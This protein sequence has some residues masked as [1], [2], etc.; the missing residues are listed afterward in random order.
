MNLHVDYA[1]KSEHT[2]DAYPG[3]VPAIGLVYEPTGELF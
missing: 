3:V 2:S 1:D